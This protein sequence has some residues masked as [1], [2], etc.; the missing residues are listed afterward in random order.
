M[1]EKKTPEFRNP[2][3]A[4]KYEFVGEDDVIKHFPGFHGNISK[5]NPKQ[6]EYMMSVEDP[7]IR[8]KKET[9]VKDAGPQK[10]AGEKVKA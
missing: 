5:V 7:H 6:A 8:L 2:E 4:E 1:A 3:V 9:K 10:D